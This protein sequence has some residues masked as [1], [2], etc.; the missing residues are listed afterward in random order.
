MT[1]KG[2]S[3]EEIGMGGNDVSFAVVIRYCKVKT[4]ASGNSV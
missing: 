2:T 3:L 4:R 1:H